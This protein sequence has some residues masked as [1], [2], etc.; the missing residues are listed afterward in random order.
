MSDGLT[1]GDFIHDLVHIFTQFN[2][3]SLALLLIIVVIIA[4]LVLALIGLMALMSG[5]FKALKML[6]RD[7]RRHRDTP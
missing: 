7:L 2:G 5:A 1:F 3:R 4:F 6:I